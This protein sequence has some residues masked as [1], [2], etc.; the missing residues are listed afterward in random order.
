M[1]GGT[2]AVF[3]CVYCCSFTV[4]YFTVLYISLYEHFLTRYVFTL[5]ATR[6]NPK[7]QDHSFSAVHG[8]LFN[9]FTTTIHT[10]GCSSF[11]NLMTRNSV[12]RGTDLEVGFGGMEW[13]DLA[14]VRDRCR[15][16]LRVAQ[17]A[18]TFLTRCEP[19]SFTRRP[20]LYGVIS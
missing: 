9:T 3:W 10:A 13:I 20:L 1:L 7:L 11:R 6:P 16:Q 17:N 18:G 19:N 15:A 12:V 14:Q 4:L 2:A 8:D 5:L